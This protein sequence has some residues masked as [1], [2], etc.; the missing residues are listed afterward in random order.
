MKRSSVFLVI[1]LMAACAPCFALQ[2]VAGGILLGFQQYD[3]DLANQDMGC[4]LIGGFGYGVS[5]EGVRFGG[6]GM[7]DSAWRLDSR[8]PVFIS[9]TRT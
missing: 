2:G 9:F 6:F 5:A 3:P 1:G 4:V 8:R 7:T